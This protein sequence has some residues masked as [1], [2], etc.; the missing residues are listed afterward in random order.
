[1][2]YELREVCAGYGGEP[3][4]A[5]LTLALR[6]GSITVVLGPSGC[7]KTTLLNLIAGLKTPDSGHR[8]GFEGVRFSYAFQE[9]RLLPWLC[10]RDN[11]L[12]ALEAA[13]PRDEALGRVELFLA[14]AGLAEAASKRPAELSGGMRQRLSLVR[15]F[16]FPSEILLLDEAFQAVDLA[17]K[18]ELMDS[19]MR[20]WREEKRT[21]VL[22]THDVEE[23][24]YLADR[25]IVLS[26]RPAAI[27]ADFP[28]EVPRADRAFGSTATMEA[29][30]RLYRLVLGGT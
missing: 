21:V 14:A 16:A 17:T 12:F 30:S 19:F 11:A 23:A 18:L 13:L 9:P 6:P 28:V 15:A 2:A 29:E 20:L 24:V 5:G 3:V 26:K 22:V 25:V 7:G 10:A 8:L 4:L 27:V 1:M